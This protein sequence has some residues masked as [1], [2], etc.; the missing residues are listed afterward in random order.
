MDRPDYAANPEFFESF[1]MY[2]GR[3][4]TERKVQKITDLKTVP[5]IDVGV[6][7]FQGG[8]KSKKCRIAVIEHD[9]HDQWM[10]KKEVF[11]KKI[12]DVPIKS[13]FINSY[14]YY[15]SGEEL[16]WLY[17]DG[18]FDSET[19][20]RVLNGSFFRTSGKIQTYEVAQFYNPNMKLTPIFVGT[21]R[22][23]GLWVKQG[24]RIVKPSGV[25]IKKSGQIKAL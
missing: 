17:I 15:E 9:S 12:D 25:Y 24:Q 3:D 6:D 7:M 14:I 11:P 1:E 13:L 19:H 22:I 18:Y 21:K 20:G 23:G 8:K 10:T 16:E 4:F 2:P 5:L